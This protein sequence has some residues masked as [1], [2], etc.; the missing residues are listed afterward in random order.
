[1]FCPVYFCNIQFLTVSKS[2]TSRLDIWMTDLHP[3][4]PVW[5]LLIPNF[6]SVARSAVLDTVRLFCFTYQISKK[7]L[8]NPMPKQERVW[9]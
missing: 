6:G 3:F 2:S 7:Q 4:I 5:A 1:M 8:E 9:F